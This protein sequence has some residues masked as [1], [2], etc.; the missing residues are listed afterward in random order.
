MMVKIANFFIDLLGVAIALGIMWGLKALSSYFGFWPW[1]GPA[2]MLA[3]FFVFAIGYKFGS[4]RW[5]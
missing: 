5:I 3:V 2:T 1:S 4:G